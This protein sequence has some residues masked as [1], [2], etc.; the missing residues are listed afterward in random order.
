MLLIQLN[1]VIYKGI[2]DLSFKIICSWDYHVSH[3]M[4]I[5]YI[6]HGTQSSFIGC[7]LSKEDRQTDRWTDR[8]GGRGQA[9]RWAGRQLVRWVGGQVGMLQCEMFYTGSQRQ[10][11]SQHVFCA[12]FCSWTCFCLSWRNISLCNVRSHMTLY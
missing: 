8:Q 5:G 10:I 11:V 7:D 9:G 4:H 1:S 12:Q 6:Y 3:V 2:L